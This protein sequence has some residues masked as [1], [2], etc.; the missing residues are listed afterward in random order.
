MSNTPTIRLARPSLKKEKD[1]KEDDLGALAFFDFLAMPDK[2][3]KK[4]TN[5]TRSDGD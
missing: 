2:P 4:V 1:G 5:L 3:T